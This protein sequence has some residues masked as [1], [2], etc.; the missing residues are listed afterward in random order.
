MSQGFGEHQSPNGERDGLGKPR[1]EVRDLRR[2]R[3]FTV[4]SANRTLPLVGRIV[5]DILTCGRA[6]RRC[7]ADDCASI[8]DLRERLRELVSE[9][10]LIGCE[11][12]D[13]S[14]EVGLVDFPAELDGERIA[15]CWRAD[16]PAIT[17]YHSVVEGYGGRLQLPSVDPI[18]TAREARR[19][20][21]EAR[22]AHFGISIAGAVPPARCDCAAPRFGPL[23]GALRG[24]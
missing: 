17:H 13:W 21:L 23:P 1:R 18:A 10:K 24:L 16:E 7:E 20:R 6:L 4:E 14:F 19:A 11:Y 15:L 9:L 8:R 12:K 2:G 3:V 22:S 5:A